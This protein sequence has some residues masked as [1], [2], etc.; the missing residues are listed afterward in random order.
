[1]TNDLAI[2]SFWEDILTE[3]Q[4]NSILNYIFLNYSPKDVF[5]YLKLEETDNLLYEEEWQNFDSECESN[6]K[7]DGDWDEQK[8]VIRKVFKKYEIDWGK[9]WFEYDK[10]FEENRNLYNDWFLQ[11]CFIE[12]LVNKY[13]A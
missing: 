11:Q 7:T 2:A 13:C 12:K 6:P 1:M 4:R 5:Q 3:E 9:L 10:A 8:K